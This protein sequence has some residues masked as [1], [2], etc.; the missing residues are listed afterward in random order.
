[1]ES[2]VVESSEV[3]LFKREKGVQF[4]LKEI[5]FKYVSY[6]PLILLCLSISVGIGYVYIRYTEP[7]FKA[8]I[9]IIV[10]PDDPKTKTSSR[11][12]DDLVAQAL[13]G[14]KNINLENEITR[15]RSVE[16]WEKVVKTGDFNVKIRN[17]G[18]IRST[19]LFQESP[20]ELVFLSSKDSI[21][22]FSLNIEKCT[23][24]FAVL[25]SSS[26]YKGLPPKIY[27][28]RRYQFQGV[29]FQL[30]KRFEIGDFTEPLVITVSPA[31]ETARQLLGNI[32]IAAIG[33][34]SILQI[35][36]RDENPTR[37]KEILDKLAVVF[38]DNDIEN[39]RL[40]S[41]NTIQ[42]IDDRLKEVQAELDSLQSRI[43]RLKKS[44]LL[45][46]IDATTDYS[47]NKIKAVSESSEKN[48]LQLSVLSILE[49]YLNDS[50]NYYRQ[51][52]TDLGLDNGF[53]SVAL[54]EFNNAQVRLEKESAQ[55]PLSKE[56]RIIKD[57]KLQVDAA[58]YNIYEII[59]NIRKELAQK[60]KLDEQKESFY[61]N[62]LSATPEAENAI[63][64]LKGQARI[65]QDLYFYLLQRKE[66]IAITSATFLSSYATIDKAFASSFPIEPKV[67]NIR[68]FSILIG[69]II[70]VLI[71]Y[72]IDL[73][74]DKVTFREQ[75]QKKM[76]IAIAG[77]VSHV[78]DPS[79]M[80]FTKSRSLEA[81]QFRMLR[82]NLTYLF[83]GNLN[84]KVILI[85]STISGE[86]KSFVSTNLSAALSL[87]EHKVALLQFD[88]RKVND[89]PLFTPIKDSLSGRGITNYLIG[90]VKDLQELAVV[91]N[92]YP[93]L[94][95]Y[96]SGPIPPNP[97]E[98]LL[99][100]KIKNLFDELKAQYDYIIV[101][102]APSG[103]VSDAFIL[104]EYTD[105]TLYIIRQ[106][107]TLLRQLDYINEVFE[108]KRLNH[109]AIVV[110]DV[111][112]GGRF[113]YYGYN[114][115][116]GYSYAYKYT[117]GYY[118]KTANT[119]YYGYL[120]AEQVNQSWWIRLARWVGFL[121]RKRK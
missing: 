85:T 11:R 17:V 42:F 18:R 26:L 75:I 72:L 83:R 80:V 119:G 73:F 82:A 96:P 28:D 90:Q 61:K 9:Q 39:K 77:E 33:K 16:L 107:Y 43:T 114:Y 34:T 57:L 88:L 22:S 64:Y 12:N 106:K 87:A 99:G 30:R 81:E 101:D 65:K 38:K 21:T 74:N 89:T 4:S 104:K 44:S 35:D 120:E 68:N 23:K 111:I 84:Q 108:Q 94:H 121:N 58:R 67:S 116:Y 69:L 115:G 45:F 66:E 98:L 113:G 59:K 32:N 50:V 79:K 7:I 24:D 118:G 54:R 40:A 92:D 95:I 105:I 109:M 19:T 29:T 52:P 102:S 46:D 97:S 2:N 91:N 1:M 76:D 49:N 13:Q 5:L 15:L 103:V 27:F 55:L 14:D 36:L 110:N 20:V 78:S 53:L 70:P 62:I 51:V 117:Y 60:V 86:G 37:A 100:P 41:S 56:N 63:V 25:G 8:G 93:N 10:N 71:I 31:I 3:S 112:L 47:R 6:L 48:E